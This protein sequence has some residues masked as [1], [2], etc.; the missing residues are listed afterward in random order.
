MAHQSLPACLSFYA[1]LVCR[2]C[3]CS[4]LSIPFTSAITYTSNGFTY[5][6]GPSKAS[7]Q[8]SL[9]FSLGNI[10]A[11]SSN[12][13]DVVRAS[14]ALHW[15]LLVA[16]LKTGAQHLVF[17]TCIVLICVGSFLGTCCLVRRV[18]SATNQLIQMLHNC[19][20]TLAVTRAAAVSAH[21]GPEQSLCVTRRRCRAPR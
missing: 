19:S 2:S 8:G 15:L 16:C 18:F 21:V 5:T 14:A 11:A 6:Y 12:C 17:S 9:T 3:T 20:C 10:D 13:T 7:Q 1:S 4:Q